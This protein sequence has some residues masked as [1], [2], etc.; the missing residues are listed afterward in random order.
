MIS[1]DK[2]YMNLRRLDIKVR[3]KII[4]ILGMKNRENYF[5]DSAFV[6]P[7]SDV[8][9]LDIYAN[10]TALTVPHML[11]KNDE[12]IYSFQRRYIY[13]IK[14][15][16]I[17]PLTG[18]IYDQNGKLIAESTSWEINRLLSEIPRPFINIPSNKLK[19]K[20]IF[21]PTT[22][23]YYHWLIQDLP[24]FL[25][26][27]EYIPDAK[28][29]LGAH[30]FKP[31]CSIME[32]LFKNNTTI[33]RYSPMQVES[34]IMVAKD[35]GM[36]SPIPPHTSVNPYDVKTLKRFFSEFYF[37]E[38]I[39]NNTKLYLSRKGW[40]RS[41]AGEEMLE[42]ELKKLG[43]TIYNGNLDFFKQ[44]KLFSKASIIMGASGAA[45]SNL[46]WVNKNSKVIQMRNEGEYFNFYSNLGKICNLNYNFIEVKKRDWNKED[47]KNILNN[48]KKYIG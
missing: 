9:R 14:N 18:L 43:F 24:V 26:A 2:L 29:I 22:P 36:G 17:D 37:N 13:E 5:L 33:K 42:T 21:L 27:Y 11:N 46:I 16:I 4:S 20:F 7:R 40:S 19:G 45:M 34:L 10:S 6:S 48:V 39:D 32:R 25:A 12:I 28:I 15:A 1:I 44:M 35:A 30:N 38:S 8:K 23:T 41:N 3:R 31:A 47:I